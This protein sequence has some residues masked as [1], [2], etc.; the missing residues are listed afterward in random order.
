LTLITT[1]KGLL[2]AKFY[3]IAQ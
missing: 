2:K 1:H 3:C